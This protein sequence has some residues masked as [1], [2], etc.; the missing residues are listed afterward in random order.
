MNLSYEHHSTKEAVRGK[1]ESAI[2]KALDIGGG[3]VQSVN[4]AWSGDRMDFSFVAMGKTIKGK[5]QITD[6]EVQVEAGLP[7]MLRPFEGKVKSR[8]LAALDEM[9]G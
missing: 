3:Q 8:I 9:F 7:L 1:L 6:A 5:A 4:Y 2:Q